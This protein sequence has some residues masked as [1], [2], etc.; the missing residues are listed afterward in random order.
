MT[1]QKVREALEEGKAAYYHVWI[2]TSGWMN[3]GE[4]C[5]DDSNDDVDHAMSR[6]E[7]FCNGKWEEVTIDED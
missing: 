5:C 7:N 1:E 3:C 2:F 4:G 6:I